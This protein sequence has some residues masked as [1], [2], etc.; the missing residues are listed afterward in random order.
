MKNY[1]N[2]IFLVSIAAVMPACGK[3]APEKVV[4]AAAL[5]RYATDFVQ[6]HKSELHDH[7]APIQTLESPLSF[8]TQFFTS[9]PAM[10]T[11][12][13]KSSYD[14]NIAITEQWQKMYCTDTLEKLMKESGIA[15]SSAQLIDSTTG[16]KHSLASCVSTLAKSLP[17]TQDVVP[18]FTLS[19]LSSGMID[20]KFKGVSPSNLVSSLERLQDIKKGEFETTEDF[21][22]RKADALSIK[23]IDDYGVDDVFP[24][25]VDVIKYS[26]CL[27]GIMYGYNPD[28]S[29]ATLHLSADPDSYGDRNFISG[30]DSPKYDTFELG[31]EYQKD[32][33]Y[34]GSNAFGVQAK[35]TQVDGVIFKVASKK[36]HFV[37]GKR[38]LSCFEKEA[39]FKFNI[40]IATAAKELPTLKALIMLKVKPPY[41]LYRKFHSEATR[42]DP[43][44]T[45]VITKSLYGDVVGIVIY[46]EITGKIVTQFPLTEKK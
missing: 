18:K 35:V 27:H 38:T 25:V 14:K 21:N 22:K 2:L 11:A 9:T 23:L 4:P 37:P 44:E 3:K 42:S 10:L 32:K 34:I 33:T 40:D 31:R 16:E 43:T 29:K 20:P 30:Y 26:T 15:I 6:E 12:K 17:V 13:D 46:S 24:F 36:I 39:L 28:T 19:S 5:D 7:S 41:V 45:K 1:C 8:V